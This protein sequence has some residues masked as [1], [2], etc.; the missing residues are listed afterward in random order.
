[1]E[2]YAPDRAL[3]RCWGR[4]PCRPGQPG[5]GRRCRGS[6]RRHPKCPRRNATGSTTSRGPPLSKAKE[7]KYSSGMTKT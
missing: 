2:T 4:G 3:A 7:P 1:M 5:L 6:G